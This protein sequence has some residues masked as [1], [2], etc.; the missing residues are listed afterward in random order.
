MT[1]SRHHILAEGVATHSSILAW[2][3]PR[4]EGAGGLQAKGSQ[5]WTPR[6][7]FPRTR[8]ASVWAGRAA[9]WRHCYS[10][11]EEPAAGEAQRL[12]QRR[13][14]TSV[15]SGRTAAQAGGRRFSFATRWP[16]G[17][18]GKARVLLCPWTCAGSLPWACSP[19]KRAAWTL[20]RSFTRGLPGG[21]LAET[22]H[23]QCRG[24]GFDPWSEN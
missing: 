5:S 21:P 1:H 6:R 19:G 20:Q 10:I 7:H 9:R 13:G 17:L 14:A 18:P 16:C 2:S 15:L 8:P 4:T 24:P 11:R 23:S 22:P 12:A 3:I